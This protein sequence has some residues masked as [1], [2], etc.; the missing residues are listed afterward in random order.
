MSLYKLI[1]SSIINE[2]TSYLRQV[3]PLFTTTHLGKMH[4]HHG[5]F[6]SFSASSIWTPCLSL[7]QPSSILILHI[8]KEAWANDLHNPECTSRVHVYWDEHWLILCITKS[9]YPCWPGDRARS[10][11]KRKKLVTD[12]NGTDKN[13]DLQRKT[14][15]KKYKEYTGSSE[16]GHCFY[17]SINF[18]QCDNDVSKTDRPRQFGNQNCKLLCCFGRFERPSAFGYTSLVVPVAKNKQ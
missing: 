16:L 14:E 1:Y 4:P 6:N 2:M 9:N 15:R 12:G 11:S 13:G 3:A 18:Q 10:T 7:Q 8:S 5:K 17:G